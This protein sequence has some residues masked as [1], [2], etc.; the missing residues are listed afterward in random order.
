VRRLV[1]D[2]SVA[3]KWEIDEVLT[4]EADFV[5]QAWEDEG[6]ELVAPAWFSC[7]VANALFQRCRRGELPSSEVAEAHARILELVNIIPTEVDLGVRALEIAFATQQSASYDTFYLA[8]AEHLD[9]ELWTA[10]ERFW[11]STRPAF[12]FVKW[13][14]NVVIVDPS[15]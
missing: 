9:C 11:R 2:T 15:E 4:P 10:D 6:T 7:E 12:P 8:L 5:R 14:G 3:L 1:I 13:L